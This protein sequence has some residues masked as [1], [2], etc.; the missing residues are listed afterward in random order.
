MLDLEGKVKDGGKC[1]SVSVHG[2]H[3]D[4]TKR[5]WGEASAA[6]EWQWI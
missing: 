1:V 6:L 4:S 5:P 3:E 2:C